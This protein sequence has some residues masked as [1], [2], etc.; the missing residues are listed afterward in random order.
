[1]SWRY[2]SLAMGCYAVVAWHVHTLGFV[3]GVLRRRVD[4][5]RPVEARVVVDARQ[6]R[7][8]EH[9]AAT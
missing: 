2:S 3:R 9:G 6:S 1:M 8:I 7:R 5:R 4:P